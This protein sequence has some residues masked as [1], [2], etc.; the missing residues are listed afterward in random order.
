MRRKPAAIPRSRAGFGEPRPPADHHHGKDQPATAKS[1]I[2]TDAVAFRRSDSM[3]ALV[4][5][6]TCGSPSPVLAG[7][8][9]D[10]IV[11]RVC[12]QSS[13]KQPSHAH[14]DTQLIGAVALIT[15]AVVWVLLAM[16]LAQLPVSRRTGSGERSITY[17]PV[18]AGS[19]PQCCS[20]AGCRDQGRKTRTDDR[21]MDVV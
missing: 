13:P 8:G 6:I 9:A 14:P 10:H 4:M 7:D 20:F 16:A 19:C 5:R 11:A 12:S 18:S 17:S 3:G 2:L 15:L 1:Q 21:K